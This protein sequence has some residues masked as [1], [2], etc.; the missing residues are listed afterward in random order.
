MVQSVNVA[1]IVNAFR[2]LWNPSLAM[3]HIIVN[4]IRNI[5]F[6][7][8]KNQGQIQAMAFDKDNCLTAPYVPEIYPPFKNAWAEC[9]ET[10][11]QENIAIVSN[12]AGTDDDSNYTEATKLEQSLGVPVLRHSEKKPSGGEALVK[13]FDHASQQKIAMVGDRILTDI[14]FGNL[15]GN[16]TIWTSQI[17]TEKGDNKAALFFRRVEHGLIRF[18]QKMNVQ[19]PHHP[20]MKT[21]AMPDYIK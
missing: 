10:F 9:K 14:L 3:P 15:N 19:P 1:G 4:D 7:Q 18:L 21:N 20:A 8:L 13:H 11:G 6:Q 2:V 5:H 16:L 12:S 17:V